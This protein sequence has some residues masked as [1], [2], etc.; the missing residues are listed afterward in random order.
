VAQQLPVDRADELRE[1]VAL[2]D[3]TASGLVVSVSGEH[4]LEALAYPLADGT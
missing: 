3:D 2:F 1:D 4:A